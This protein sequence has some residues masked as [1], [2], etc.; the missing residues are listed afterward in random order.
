MGIAHRTRLHGHRRSA[1]HSRANSGQSKSQFRPVA[2][3]TCRLRHREMLKPIWRYSDDLLADVL[4]KVALDRTQ[5][6]GM[7]PSG[8]NHYRDSPFRVC[9]TQRIGE[10]C[11][12]RKV[13]VFTRAIRMKHPI[14]VKE[15]HA[16]K[17]ECLHR[18]P[19]IQLNKGDAHCAMLGANV[20]LR[21]GCNALQ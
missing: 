20:R 9:R 15:Q 7:A 2:C 13:L 14:Y 1:M 10:R 19:E 16:I 4:W 11:Q 5:P 17:T 6:L 21:G 8:R 3:T 12:A 18:K